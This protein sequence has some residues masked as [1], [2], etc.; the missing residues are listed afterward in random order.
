M[1]SL[2]KV[3][4]KLEQ[5]LDGR[6]INDIKN[7]L[8]E[9]ADIVQEVK[10]QIRSR[11]LLTKLLNGHVEDIEDELK[12]LMDSC[13]DSSIFVVFTEDKHDF[14]TILDEIDNTKT[15]SLDDIVIDSFSHFFDFNET[16]VR[17]MI[18]TKSTA[19]DFKCSVSQA[20]KDFH[21]FMLDVKP[22][23]FVEKIRNTDKR[24]LFIFGVS[25]IDELDY[26]TRK[27]NIHVLISNASHESQ[28]LLSGLRQLKK[29]TIK[30]ESKKHLEEII[31]TLS[32]S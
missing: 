7:A 8:T 4:T 17:N 16:S 22:I 30:Y 5:A 2:Q 25:L 6:N 29:T 14:M 24:K 31:H 23:I 18:L 1:T 11:E 32:K 12:K 26:L 21:K 28:Q 10:L 19:K 27:Y 13:V 9:Y 15:V 20:V 3:K